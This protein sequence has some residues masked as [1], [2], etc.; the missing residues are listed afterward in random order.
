MRWNDHTG[1]TKA[2]DKSEGSPY[3][4]IPKK[5]PEQLFNGRVFAP[6]RWPDIRNGTAHAWGPSLE[7]NKSLNNTRLLVRSL[8][9]ADLS[10]RSFSTAI[11]HASS[12][13][14]VE[15]Q[16]FVEHRRDPNNPNTLNVRAAAALESLMIRT[17]KHLIVVIPAWSITDMVRRLL[18]NQVNL[19]QESFNRR[20]KAARPGKVQTYSSA[21]AVGGYSYIHAKTWIFDDPNFAVIGSANTKP[22]GA[23]THDARWPLEY[24]NKG[25]GKENRC[26]TD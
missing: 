1:S 8:N 2:L 16:Y 24:A 10:A 21:D 3:P 6:C 22:T 26:R 15:D 17:S 25:D 9:G 5:V 7:V 13:I 12:L 18:H 20:I 23:G 11:I 14:Y 4:V 19:S